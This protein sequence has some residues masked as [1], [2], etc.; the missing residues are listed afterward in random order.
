MVLIDCRS[1]KNDSTKRLKKNGI[2]DIF[3]LTL[4]IVFMDLQPN[5]WIINIM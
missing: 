2:T 1:S 3:G 4:L 5:Y